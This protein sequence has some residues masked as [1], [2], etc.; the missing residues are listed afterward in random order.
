[1]PNLD[2]AI[3]S[4]EEKG[5]KV[6]GVNKQSP[7][8]KEAFIHPKQVRY[9]SFVGQHSRS[10]TTAVVFVVSFTRSRSL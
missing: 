6:V 8:W 5:W 10:G 1:M 2:E 7:S 4:A 9:P 3:A